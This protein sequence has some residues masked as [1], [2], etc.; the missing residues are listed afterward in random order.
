M[1]HK[2]A[3]AHV[4]IDS[5]DMLIYILFYSISFIRIDSIMPIKVYQSC[6]FSIKYKTIH[7]FLIQVYKQKKTRDITKEKHK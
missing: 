7:Y 6:N 5:H 4:D 3:N 2:Q 1:S